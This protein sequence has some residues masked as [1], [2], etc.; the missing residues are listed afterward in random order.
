M[1]VY[2]FCFFLTVFNLSSLG[3]CLAFLSHSIPRLGGDTDT[4]TSVILHTLVGQCKEDSEAIRRHQGGPGL[5]ETA[6]THRPRC[7]SLL[8]PLTLQLQLCLGSPD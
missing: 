5:G 4:S 2:P 3:F 8:F 1:N 6:G 7:S